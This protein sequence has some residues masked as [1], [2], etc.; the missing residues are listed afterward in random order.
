LL[1]HLLLTTLLSGSPQAPSDTAF[2]A[3]A[4]VDVTPSA[5]ATAVAAFKQY[6]DA[7]R[8]D[9]GYSRFELFEQVGRPGHLSIIE[10]F[11]NQKAFDAHQAAAQTKEWRSKL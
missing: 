9:E 4:Y 1:L 3:V 11:A 7:S 8:K 6:R 2:Y 10:A 5:K